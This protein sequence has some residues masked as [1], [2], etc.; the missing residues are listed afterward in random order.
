MAKYA[1]LIGVGSYQNTNMLEP[2]LTA[3]NDVEAV[4][5]V[6]LHPEM[7]GFEHAIPLL[8]PDRLTMEEAIEEFFRRLG[9]EDLGLLLFAGRGVRD[10]QGKAYFTTQSTRK[11]SDGDLVKATAIPAQVVQD[12]MAT[13]PARQQVMILDCGFQGVD[14]MEV[15]VY[16]GSLNLRGQ[17]GGQGR[18]ILLGSEASHPISQFESHELSPYTHLLV[19]GITTGKADRNHDQLV[20]VDEL[21]EY[22]LEQLQPLL[23]EGYPELIVTRDEDRAINL[24]RVRHFDPRHE[25]RQHVESRVEKGQ[26]SP[27]GRAILDKRRVSLGLSVEEA[28]AIEDDVLRP[29]RE[30]AKDLQ[31]YR[32]ALTAA[33]QLE[34]PLGP[35]QQAELEEFQAL[36]ELSDTEVNAIQQAVMQPFMEQAA[37]QQQRQSSYE[38]AFR[39]AIAFE[40]PLPT[41]ERLKLRQQQRSLELPDEV[42]Q[43]IEAQVL[44][45]N[46]KQRQRY[47]QNLQQL[48]QAWYQALS[49]EDPPSEVTMLRLQKLQRSLEI[50]PEHAE[51][52]AQRVHQQV[53]QDLAEKQARLSQYEALFTTL[54]SQ[55]AVLRKPQRDRLAQMQQ[56]LQLS[57]ADIATVEEQAT[58]KIQAQRQQHQRNLA[59]YQQEC[60]R[61]LQE[62]YPLSEAKQQDLKRLQTEL[63]LSEAE[64]AKILE[65]LKLQ[66]E[67]QRHAYAQNKSR[68]EQHYR[69]VER[70]LAEAAQ[71]Q[72]KQIW[73]E[74]GLKETDV[75]QI[76]QQVDA[77]IAADLERQAESRLTYQRAYNHATRQQFP[78]SDEQ[79]SQLLELGQSLNLTQ[80]EMTQIEDQVNATYETISDFSGDSDLDPTLHPNLESIIDPNLNPVPD[81]NLDPTLNTTF[82]PVLGEDLDPNLDSSP[83]P[84][85]STPDSAELDGTPPPA[86]S[87]SAFM[88]DPLSS[89]RN[90]EYSV[91]QELLRDSLWREAD[92]ETF[93]VMLLATDRS[94]EAW[95]SP[96]SLL[97]IPC[98]DLA[99]ISHLWDKHSNGHFGFIAQERIFHGLVQSNPKQGDRQLIIDLALRLK[100]MWKAGN[101]YPLFRNYDDL[102]FSSD[103]VMGHLPARWYWQL[104]PVAALKVGTVGSDRSFGGADIHM[105]ANLMKRLRECNIS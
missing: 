30:H 89:E 56:E 27:V 20:S 64:A 101:F 102:T 94:R 2:S 96:D 24:A 70:P 26:F 99:T 79:R 63:Q 50:Q 58:A 46:Q 13:S 23:T 80:E 9:R 5:E 10:R 12:I 105:F 29:F 38:Q 73:H 49:A 93:R 31:R 6:L 11:N 72:L 100:W 83:P 87:A 22:V 85:T 42:A 81:P 43:A 14:P 104:S 45:A 47:H 84:P 33:L 74:L 3:R 57:D 82:D 98:T 4:R 1:L 76:E 78:L 71:E 60:A 67:A 17:L 52:I 19:E 44:A 7:G 55:E 37:R 68:Y 35:R 77:E 97:R 39:Q 103:A 95:L 16:N 32:Q 18:V 40:Y 66:A 90:V 88:A 53:Q 61:L 62:E 41:P 54:V 59:Y 15:A 48:E 91:L 69:T 75:W 51:A 25:Y 21:H 86:S 34:Y 8:D 92:R 65:H 28:Q 36:L